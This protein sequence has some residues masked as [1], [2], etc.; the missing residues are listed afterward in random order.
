MQTLVENL[1]CAGE[2]EESCC[3]ITVLS[4]TTEFTCAGVRVISRVLLEV[5]KFVYECSSRVVPVPVTF[6]LKHQALISLCLATESQH[7]EE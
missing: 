1:G 5:L 2:V 6:Y 3:F 7:A 4:L